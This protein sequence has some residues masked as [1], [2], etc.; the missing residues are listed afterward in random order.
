MCVI[1]LTAFYYFL[2]IDRVVVLGAEGPP[3]FT[4]LRTDSQVGSIYLYSGQMFM[5]VVKT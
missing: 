2:T 1:I 4:G 5:F 3:T